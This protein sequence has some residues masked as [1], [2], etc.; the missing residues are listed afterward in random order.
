MQLLQKVIANF[1]GNNRP[2]TWLIQNG[3]H[4]GTHGNWTQQKSLHSHTN[5]EFDKAFPSESLKQ[6]FQNPN[7]ILNSP[8]GEWRQEKLCW[9]GE[10]P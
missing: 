8:N 7:T 9:L 10:K 3:M 6:S 1:Q 4:N 2:T 5:A